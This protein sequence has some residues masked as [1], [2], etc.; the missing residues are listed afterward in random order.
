MRATHVGLYRL[1]VGAIVFV[2]AHSVACQAS[3]EPAGDGVGGQDATGG[4][5]G[6]AGATGEGSGGGGTGGSPTG[7][8]VPPEGMA[9]TNGD[10]GG[11]GGRV[12]DNDGMDA[13]GGM[14][15]DPD[16][17]KM[18]LGPIEGFRVDIPCKGKRYGANLC[19]YDPAALPERLSVERAV[20][21]S[22]GVQYRVKAH[23][24]ALVEPM[25]YVKQGGVSA[26][27][28]TDAPEPITGAAP[29]VLVF[30]SYAL[31]TTRPASLTYL[32]AFHDIEHD[33]YAIDYDLELTVEGGSRIRL[34]IADGNDIAVGNEKGV[35][36]PDVAPFPEAY[37][38]QFI[39]VDFAPVAE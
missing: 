29:G 34:L 20:G 37:D 24:R 10:A 7:E 1:F 26:S 27:S 14:E 19:T 36:V 3:R 23:V 4:D 39:Q 9:G 15:Q 18:P 13:M 25:R 17:A 2:A 6:T 11:M 28:A 22:P 33:V 8:E 38:G 12:P 31:A 21:G 16:P 35:K 30:R 5:D 32:N